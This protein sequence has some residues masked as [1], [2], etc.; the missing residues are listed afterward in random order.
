MPFIKRRLKISKITQTIMPKRKR[1]MIITIAIVVLA[2]ILFTSLFKLLTDWFWFQ[3]IGYSNIFTTILGTKLALGFGVGIFVFILLYL[4]FL[5]VHRF[6][7][8]SKTF[9][10]R[11]NSG[12]NVQMRTLELSPLI[13]KF[14]IPVFLFIGIIAGL[15]ASSQWETFL[16][17][18]NATP[19]GNLDPLFERDIGYYFFTL[20][21]IQSAIG[22]AITIIVIALIGSVIL[23]FLL[24]ALEL[25]KSLKGVFKGSVQSVVTSA[26]RHLSL[27]FAF[28]FLL[29]ALKTYFVQIPS[30]VYSTTSPFTGAGYTDVNIILPILQLGAIISLV[31]AVLLII[32]AFK[33][34]TRFLITS[35]AIY[36]LV[37]VIGGWLAPELVQRLI[38]LPNELVKE[39]PYIKH[40]ITST[41]QAYGIANIEKRELEGETT[42]TMTDIENNQSTIQNVRLWDR[43]PLLDTFGQ[44]QEIRTYYDFVS[45]DNDRYTIDDNYR[46]V[47]LSP[48]E[49]DAASLPQ[50]NFINE[51]LTFTHGFGLTLGPVNEVTPE[52]LPVLF[53]QDLPPKSDVDNLNIAKPGI[54]YGEL[55]NEYVV[56]NTEAKEFDYPSGDENVF[57]EYE[58]DGGVPINSFYRKL[59]FSLRFQS[60]KFFFS[61]DINKDSRVMMYRDID[62]RVRRVLPFL[63]FDKDPYLVITDNEELKWIYDAYTISDRYPYSEMVSDAKLRDF[64]DDLPI[65]TSNLNYI[66]NSVK[67]VIDAYTGKMQFYVADPNDPLI[68]TYEKIFSGSFKP[69]DSITDNL[70]AHIR[71]PEDLFIFQTNLY[72]TYHMEEPQIFY[73][74]EDQWEIPKKP[75]KDTS[76]PMMR[77]MIMKLPEEEKEE[78]ILML[79]FTP[80]GKDNL[81]AWIVARNDGEHYGQIVVYR[82]PKQTLVFGPQQ[83]MNRINQDPEI[84]RQ[85]SLWDQRG[86]QV[87]SGN[88]LVI[89]IEK[90]LLYVQPIYLRAEGG[91][92][93]ELKR[94]IVAY[95]NRIQ[96]A[97]TLNIALSRLFSDTAL[98][99]PAEAT[100]IPE[101]TVEIQET[102]LTTRAQEVYEQAIEAQRQGDWTTY[103]SKIEE[104]GNIL[105]QL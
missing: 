30:L 20:P 89:P 98:E 23:Y 41:Q 69:L 28:F 10:F 49:L 74:K 5:L 58:G 46:Q 35:F 90:S 2:L 26:K 83:I 52:G 34:I 24:G 71:Y 57:T 75:G 22:F 80:R 14:F 72:A 56:V 94:V 6:A 32:H 93:P 105:N 59:L 13:K 11:Q 29:I 100:A 102:D 76:D 101:S 4:N 85:I 51:H 50:R 1:Y 68:K 84:S 16:K 86:S 67:I 47:L 55:T 96:M 95:E 73:N 7:P 81:S 27:L 103:G 12:T 61:N 15:I 31:I 44:I 97:E 45:I 8:K 62:D 92:I 17:Y 18:L 60:T 66:R 79:P 36:I 19:F 38:V 82:F 43:E 65:A 42:L 88:L 87:I 37:V 53:V 99:E 77:H 91:K 33:S 64:R 54:Y 21:F 9:T 48:R 39:T 3:E 78:Y 25:K 70:Y 104:L 40:N 63:K